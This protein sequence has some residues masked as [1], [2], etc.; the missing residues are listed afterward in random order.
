MQVKLIIAIIVVIAALST[1]QAA[2]DSAQVFRFYC[3]QCHGLQGSGDG[4][5]VTD[6]FATDPRDFTNKAEMEKLSDADIKNVILDGGPSVSKSALMPPW[7]ET[8]TASEVDG[9]V[10]HL[11]GFCGCEGTGG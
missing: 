3:A 11:R 4:V 2:A 9:L 7:S 8:L 6:D 1:H 10:Q 5:N